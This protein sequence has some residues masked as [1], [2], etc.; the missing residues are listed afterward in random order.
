MKC[1]IFKII[2]NLIKDNNL[3]FPLENNCVSY[4]LIVL[5]T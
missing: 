3:T 4:M 1:Y 2:V 5:V